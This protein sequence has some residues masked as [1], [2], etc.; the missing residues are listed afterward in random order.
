MEPEK[1]EQS[2]FTA[3]KQKDQEPEC[4]QSEGM[5]TLALKN[6][7]IIYTRNLVT[8]IIQVQLQLE[9]C[10]PLTERPRF[11]PWLPNMGLIMFS[12]NSSQARAADTRK[13]STR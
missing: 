3:W 13:K 5:E 8:V 11:H 9:H 6:E 7:N 4:D 10:S 2:I 1:T 12:E